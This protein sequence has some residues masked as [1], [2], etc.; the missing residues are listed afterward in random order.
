MSVC[1]EDILRL[2]EAAYAGGR[3][4]SKTVLTSRAMLTKH[5]QR[6]LDKMS[7]LEHFATVAKGTAQ[8]LPRV[9]EEYD[10][11]SVIFLR[12]E[13]KGDS[14][15]VAEVARL[16]H[17]CFPNPTVILQEAGDDVAV[18]V[19]LTR[20]SYAERGATVVYDVEST[21]LFD[22]GD[23]RYVPFLDS[24]AF[25][26]LPQDDLLSYLRAIASCVRLSQAIG[27]LGFYPTCAS[28]DRE[29]LLGL[30]ADYERLQAGADALGEQH[31]AK[32]I[33]P[34]DSARIRMQ[35]KIAGRELDAKVEEI[36]RICHA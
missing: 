1:W 7:R 21:G 28:Q 20:R 35:M 18:S 32:D 4:V 34:N 3:R 14:Q 9:D 29:R 11:Q 33:S 31:R 24:L 8:V 23:E 19:D 6:T 13:M 26:R 36:R 30:V 27:A 10:I 2:P 12:C 5:E 17:G 22:P 16:L 25:E 15:A